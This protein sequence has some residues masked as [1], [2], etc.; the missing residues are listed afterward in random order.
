MA[1]LVLLIPVWMQSQTLNKFLSSNDVQIMQRA[2]F[3]IHNAQF[4][5]AESLLATSD[6]S[7][8]I[9][10]FL[11]QVLFF[12]RFSYTKNDSFAD[13]SIH[14]GQ[15]NKEVLKNRNSKSDLFFLAGTQGYLG[16][17]YA[18]KNEG[19][20]TK[21]MSEGGD[22]F[23][24]LSELV[25]NNPDFSECHLGLGIY[26]GMVSKLP[27]VFKWIIYPFGIKG[28]MESALNSLDMASKKDML[29]KADAWF[30][31][32]V[33]LKEDT[34]TYSIYDS[35]T[36]NYSQNPF[37][38]FMYG[39]ILYKNG[40]LS[41]AISELEVATRLLD[42]TIFPAVKE[43]VITKLGHIFY[44][45]K[46]YDKSLRYWHQ[47]E[48]NQ[49]LSDSKKSEVYQYLLKNYQSL[50]DTTNV[51]KYSQLCEKNH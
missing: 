10:N 45:L 29:T 13:Q 30:W 36:T 47:L 9:K 28:D 48:N 23:N 18:S 40:H 1:I 14:Y 16:L 27:T 17:T 34:L 22:G 25:K 26:K 46:E 6:C 51:N 8:E 31:K 41:K 4:T 44:D 15:M 43:G 38:H 35:L 5:E 19:S 21:A 42:K 3:F 49:D 20:I 11:S 50:N 39:N 37:Y 2:Q 33:F 24:G 12:W 7:V 32:A